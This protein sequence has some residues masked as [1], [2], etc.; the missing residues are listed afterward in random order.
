MDEGHEVN[1]RIWY[2]TVTVAAVTILVLVFLACFAALFWAMDRTLKHVL[3]T[4]R[5][6]DDFFHYAVDR[7]RWQEYQKL[8]KAR[9]SLKELSVEEPPS[10]FA[11]KDTP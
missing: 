4:M 8:K 9:A 6:V 1:E 5:A 2:F 3:G 10:F 11:R 7:R